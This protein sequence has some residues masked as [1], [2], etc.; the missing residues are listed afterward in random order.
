M[1][2]WP[3]TTWAGDKPCCRPTRPRRTAPAPPCWVS[4]YKW[5][6]QRHLTHISDRWQRDKNDDLQYAL[7]NGVGMETWENI[8]GI[9]NEM[10]PRDSEAVRR[11]AR[12]ERRFA[13]L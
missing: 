7:F 3:T 9:W 11:I 8:W 5:L 2:L 6:E 1:R 12:I 4:K 13:D 10:T